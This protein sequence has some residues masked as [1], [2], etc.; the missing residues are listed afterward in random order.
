MK[1][2]IIY[3]IW[4]IALAWVGILPANAQKFNKEALI[5]SNSTLWQEGNSLYVD[6]L[7][8]VSNL[9][10]DKDRTLTLT[11]LLIGAQNDRVL[12][13]IIIN[14]SRREKAYQRTLLL[15]NR[16]L[17]TLQSTGIQMPDGQ[18]DVI[19]YRQVIAYEAWMGNAA[20][21]MEV[22]LCG[23]A[24]HQEELHQV[25]VTDEVSTELK[26]MSSIVPEIAYIEVDNVRS[27]QYEAHLDFP[28][29]QSVIL[30]N[31]MNNRSE[32]Q[33]IQAMLDKIQQN[34]KLI[35]KEVRIEGFASPEGP[36]SLNEQL[37]QNRA[38]ALKQYLSRN[39]NISANLYKVSFGGENW[40]GLIKALETSS[41]KEKDAFLKIIKETPDDAQRKQAIK[42]L[43][44]GAPY[45]A[46]LKELYPPLR[47]SDCRI[48]YTIINIDVADITLTAYPE[49]EVVSLNAAAA[50][51]SKRDIESARKYLIQANKKT[52]EYENNIGVLYFLEGDWKQAVIEFQKAA[53]RGNRAAQTNL[54][55]IQKQLDKKRNVGKYEQ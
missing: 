21:D 40:N 39:K 27:E 33:N 9:S 3:S 7:I 36:L 44:G 11:P 31:F 18:T 45:R 19:N 22:E 12:P 25:L 48:D 24:G 15:N 42:Q 28:V 4:I 55:R 29:G 5:I 51:L 35:I 2:R 17:P 26:R 13:A 16:T 49:E 52:A 30:P 20:L 32:M 47:K 6:M 10:I 50:A 38:E 14:G 54:L 1:K 53:D 8:D 23:C 43:D 41:L 37:S 34:K 46:M